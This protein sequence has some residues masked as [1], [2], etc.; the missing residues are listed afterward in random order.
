MPRWVWIGGLAPMVA[1]AAA[2]GGGDGPTPPVGGECEGS[3]SPTLVDLQPGQMYL[4]PNATVAGCVELAQA[5]GRY[6]LAVVNTNSSP[7]ASV[8]FRL[9][10]VGGSAASIA[11]TE[12]TAA[13]SVL[14]HGARP[15]TAAAHSL[16][17]EMRHRKAHRDM[18]RR[19]HELMRSLPVRGGRVETAGMAAATV[20]AAAVSRTVGA[21]SMVRIPDI[22]STV[23]LCSQL[24]YQEI[25]AR[26]VYSGTRAIIVEDVAAPLAGQ[27]DNILTA[28]GQE[29]DQVMF[30]ILT[31]NFGNPLRLDAQ[32]DDNDAI[33]MVISPQVN[34]FDGVAGFVISC[35]FGSRAA[36]PASNEGEYFY[37]IVPTDASMEFFS[38]SGELTR[39][40]WRRIMR[41]TLIHEVKHLTGYAERISRGAPFEDSWL[42]EATAMV[43][44][45]LYART[46]Y[47]VGWR[48]NVTYQESVFCDVRPG[49]VQCPDAPAIMIA[50]FVLLYD[51]LERVESLSPLGDPPG[52]DG[53]S[54]YGSGWSFV[55]WILDHYATTEAAFLMPLTQGPLTGVANLEARAGRP[56]AE[57]LSHWSLANALD[58]RSNF[59]PQSELIA[60]PSWH[61]RNM[62]SSLNSD[63]ANNPTLFSR[64]YPLVPRAVTFGSFTQPT[65]QVA[66]G[67]AAY[68]E[69][70]GTAAGQQLLEFR[71]AQDGPL[72]GAIRVG[73]VRVQ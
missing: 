45:E 26:T 68:F 41:S 67:T 71:G 24:P 8:S 32:L 22:E 29:F 21:T 23:T 51:Y 18:V 1:L 30:P 5:S 40:N 48:D 66:G 34:A 37:A 73:I 53:S 15:S 12:A 13:P 19:N 20:S 65:V 2:C 28:M 4:S 44:E 58:S 62:Y 16:G 46:V 10:G 17:R 35:D 43:A 61:Y 31:Q 70:S 36:I 25:E 50:H 54:F 14:Q 47:S 60:H 27:M 3:V 11:A 69:L 52:E 63:F 57:M 59:A 49:A 64:P 38:P 7:A 56:F 6:V 33:V 72:P 42:E 39:P 9:R 55:R